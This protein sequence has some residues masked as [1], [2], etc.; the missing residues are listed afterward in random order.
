LVGHSDGGL[1]SRAAITQQSNYPGVTVT[2]LTTLG[3]PHTGSFIADIAED[4]DHGKCNARNPILQAVCL[5]LH[6]VVQLVIADLGPEATTELTG[7]SLTP[8]NREQR[9]GSCPVT[10]IAGTFF[11]FPLPPSVLPTYYNPSDGLVGQAS[12][13]AQS[14]KTIWGTP[15]PA[16]PI[17]NFQVG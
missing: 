15:I 1:W 11:N 7:D 12:A 17:P 6:K 9:M 5:S 4:T 10:G 3:T 2:S 14:S 8:W 13:L 16:P